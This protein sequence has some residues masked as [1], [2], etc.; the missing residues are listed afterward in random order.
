MHLVPTF[1]R[2][3]PVLV[4]LFMT[5][6]FWRPALLAHKSII[7]G[8]SMEHGLS[9]FTLHARSLH[10]L[11]QLLWSDKVF[12][13]DPIF[14]EAQGGFANPFNMISAWVVAPVSGVIYA[15]NF[16]HWA[17]M[18]IGGIGLLMLCRSLGYSR[19]SACF[20]A[21]AVTFSRAWGDAQ[22]NPAIS[23]A[24][25]WIPWLMWAL[26]VW[27][28][29]PNLRSAILLAVA[30]ALEVLA[31][32]PQALH[33]ALIYLVVVIIVRAS[34]RDTRREWLRTWRRRATTGIL[35]LS[36]GLGL[37]A[38]QLLPL[39][40]LVGLSNRSGGIGIPWRAPGEAYLRGFLYTLSLESPARYLPLAGSLF[41][42]SLASLAPVFS[43]SVKTWSHLAATALM[44]LLGFEWNTQIFSFIYDHHLI[45]G[46][47]YFRSTMMYFNVATL[48][49]GILAGATIDG[50]VAW[51]S[52]ND[53]STLWANRAQRW[54]IITMLAIALLWMSAVVLLHLKSVRVM[55]YASA[56]AAPVAAA[57]LVRY[58]RTSL[59]PL[60]ATMLLAAECANLRLHSFHFA[61]AEV[62]R[63]PQSVTAIKAAPAWN[64]FKVFSDSLAITYGFADPKSEELEFRMLRMLSSIAGMTNLLWA[65]P[66]LSLDGAMSLPLE[67]RTMIDSRLKDEVHGHEGQPGLRLIDF[68]S[69]RFVALDDTVSTPAFRTFW[70]A[71]PDSIW[72][73]ENI[74]A[75][76]RFQTYSQALM[77]RS[78]DE[79]LA[80]I[81]KLKAPMLVV[82]DPEMRLPPIDAS[83]AATTGEG[84][85]TLTV[86]KARSTHYR[87]KISAPGPVWFFMA[88]AN[89]P[90]WRAYL[91]GGKT[92]LYSADVLGK[93]VHIPA[94][95]HELRVEFRSAS[96]IW[97]AGASCISLISV[98]LILAIGRRRARS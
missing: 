35:A 23:D 43:K 14:A 6:V 50:I 71:T 31:G 15:A 96:F 24:L 89:Y 58:R 63:E 82:E 26:E 40:E 74:A 95:D 84:A 97:G 1:K 69:I 68:L 41:V 21:I 93:A 60:T 76:P 65:P 94:G 52:G 44:L 27:L 9:Q 73:M 11:G 78:P 29:R 51:A 20:A 47:H 37:S 67:R 91:D 86:L 53:P 75:R 28:A 87:F 72:I 45:P 30:A 62:I 39:W 42:C 98:I 10:D 16:F 17:S 34:H 4:L 19:W 38:V 56:V 64:D 55:N 90:G 79:A 61:D 92:P 81:E 33:A 80:A 49:L 3:L 12:G 57:I 13:G 77:V 83:T 70:H 54:R 85:A 59:L 22:E 46:L 88:D 48:G 32:Y 8:D 36:L 5:I 7:H 66:L 18:L 2:L 25:T